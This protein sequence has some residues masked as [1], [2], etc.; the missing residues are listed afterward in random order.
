MDCL[1]FN[2]FVFSSLEIIGINLR[3]TLTLNSFLT[4]YRHLFCDYKKAFKH[5]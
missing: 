2:I 1:Q 4:N 3:S 5:L